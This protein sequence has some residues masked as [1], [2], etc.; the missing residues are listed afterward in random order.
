MPKN[1]ESVIGLEIHAQLKT[2]SK[3]FCSCDNFSVQSEANL[4]TCPICM[5]MPG[6]LP[7]AN[8]QAI[9]WTYF[10]GLALNAKIPDKFNFERKNY[11]YP[12]LPKAYQITSQN[13]PPVVGGFLEIDVNGVLRKIR[14]N[15]I[16]LEEDAGKLIHP[17]NDGYSLV[18]LNLSGYPAFRNSDRARS[19]ITI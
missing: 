15:H 10:L 12:D 6:V 9:E 11:F 3:M 16:H 8:R 1:Y 13:K 17:K 14:I 4:N 19:P 2:Q 5:G 7:K 18:D